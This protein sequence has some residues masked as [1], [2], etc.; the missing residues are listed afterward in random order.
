MKKLYV[1]EVARLNNTYKLKAIAM[2]ESPW[3]IISLTF[4]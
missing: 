4:I 1:E 3:R 2:L